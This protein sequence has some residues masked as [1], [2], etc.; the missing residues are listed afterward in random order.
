MATRLPRTIA[1]SLKF[2]EK[3]HSPLVKVR[4]HEKKAERL[5]KV[6]KDA[7]K[8]GDPTMP[9]LQYLERYKALEHLILPMQELTK[10]EFK[11]LLAKDEVGPHELLGHAISKLSDARMKAV[12]EDPRIGKLNVLLGRRPLAR[13]VD[14]NESLEDI[15]IRFK[16]FVLK[17]RD[18]KFSLGRN[19]YKSAQA[20][21]MYF[22]IIRF[23]ADPKAKKK[24]NLVKDEDVI[25]VANELFREVSA[26]LIE[27]LQLKHD[28]FF[29][30]G[31]RKEKALSAMPRGPRA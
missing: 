29:E 12:M 15:G 1:E 27:E 30:V 9:H 19:S 18:L 4:T 2:K 28:D 8:K 31:K 17:K 3:E 10:K 25:G 21:A 22:T 6:E 24:S 14:D 13:I 11:G 26:H 23:A 5:R 20:L 16:D 7:T